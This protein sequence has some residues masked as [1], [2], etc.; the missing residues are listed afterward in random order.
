MEDP[1]Q[2]TWRR[3]AVQEQKIRIALLLPELML[4]NGAS[5]DSIR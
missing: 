5:S 3:R 2:Q 1:L 4:P